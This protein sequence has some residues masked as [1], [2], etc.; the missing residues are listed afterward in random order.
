MISLEEHTLHTSLLSPQSRNIFDFGQ[1]KY[2]K[3]KISYKPLE[4]EVDNNLIKIS[5]LDTIPENK[6]PSILTLFYQKTSRIIFLEKINHDNLSYEIYYNKILFIVALA[7]SK[8]AKKILFDDSLKEIFNNHYLLQQAIK[9]AK[10]RFY[11][12]LETIY[13]SS[14]LSSLLPS[15]LSLSGSSSTV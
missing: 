6:K 11:G 5:I 3:T 10:E 15:S 7:I 9:I 1:K 8:G 13:L 4:L 2:Q 14:S 12:H